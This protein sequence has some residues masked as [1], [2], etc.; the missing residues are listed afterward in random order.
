MQSGLSTV[1]KS[2]IGQR[3]C[4][5]YNLALNILPNQTAN[6]VDF[7]VEVYDIYDVT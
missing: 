3:T 7:S 2:K 5:F 6:S 4:N 1:V